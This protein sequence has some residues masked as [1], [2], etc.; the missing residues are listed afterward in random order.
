MQRWEVQILVSK[1]MGLIRWERGTKS[2]GSE[3]MGFHK[4]ALH[5][6]M[7]KLMHNR[8]YISRIHVIGLRAAIQLYVEEIGKGN[9]TGNAKKLLHIHFNTCAHYIGWQW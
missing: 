1:G 5:G 3:S 8:P 2:V 4:H 7:W 6:W 9:V